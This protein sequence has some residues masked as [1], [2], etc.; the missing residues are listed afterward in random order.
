MDEDRSLNGWY[1][2]LNCIYADRNFYRSIDSIFVHLVEVSSALGHFLTG[3]TKVASSPH[4]LIAKS[5][6][7]WMTL[8]G[9][10]GFSGAEELIWVKFPRV[11]PYCVNAPCLGSNTCK[12]IRVTVNGSPRAPDWVRLREVGSESWGQRPSNLREWQSMFHAVYPKNDEKT[13]EEL[14][15][16]LTEE[17]GEL[18]E[19]IRLIPVSL[20]FFVNEAVDVFAWL[21]ALA[22]SYDR[23]N[24]Q[25]GD[26]LLAAFENAFS[27]GCPDCGL[28]LC[29]CEPIHPDK[30]GRLAKEVPH[31]QFAHLQKVIFSPA[32]YLRVF[33]RSMKVSQHLD[34]S[35]GDNGVFPA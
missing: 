9:K 30:I 27:A 3:K 14:Y 1:R 18:G 16:R 23:T 5:L 21:M 33:G 6:S 26:A 20:A 28:D 22:N 15:A 35:N 19:A 11:C 7:W 12:P 17:I 29:K 24:P 13:N 32:D 34:D 2:E 31:D 8:A 25:R 10:V 4:E